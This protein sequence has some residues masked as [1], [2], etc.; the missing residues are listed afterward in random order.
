MKKIIEI[1]VLIGIWAVIWS[2]ILNTFFGNVENSH[3]FLLNVITSA[4]VGFA[5]T[6]WINKRYQK[7]EQKE[8][9][10]SP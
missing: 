6:A 5:I 10:A 4:I 1:L 8:Q 7:K 9:Q 3:R 2:L